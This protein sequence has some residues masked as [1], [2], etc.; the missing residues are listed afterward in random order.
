MVLSGSG[1]QRFMKCSVCGF[2]TGLPDIWEDHIAKGC[3]DPNS[4]FRLP[5][6]KEQEL[7]EQDAKGKQLRL[8]V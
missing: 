4:V 3:R 5:K 1:K 6:K 8:G 2:S 7:R